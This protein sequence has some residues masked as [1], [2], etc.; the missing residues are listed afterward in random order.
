MDAHTA[1]L[2]GDPTDSQPVE[3]PVS[4]LE[5]PP[6]TAV[7]RP[8]DSLLSVQDLDTRRRVRRNLDR[9]SGCSGLAVPERDTLLR[10]SAASRS[11]SGC[12]TR[13]AAW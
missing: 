13:A 11:F 5:L 3:Q 1:F 2:K 6:V 4:D 8:L 12:A 10:P 9:E 7:L